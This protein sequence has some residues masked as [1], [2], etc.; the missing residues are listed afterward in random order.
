L[1]RCDEVVSERKRKFRTSAA[2]AM[3][4]SDLVMMAAKTSSMFEYC[5]VAHASPYC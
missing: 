3:L 2:S 5:L 4:V 1:R